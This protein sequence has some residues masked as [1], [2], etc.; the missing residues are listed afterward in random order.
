MTLKFGKTS[1]NTKNNLDSISVESFGN[2]ATPTT[3]TQGVTKQLEID[4]E[5]IDLDLE[6]ITL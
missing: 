2:M 1:I 5:L 4:M 3:Q 6:Q